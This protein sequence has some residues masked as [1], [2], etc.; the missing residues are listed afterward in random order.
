LGIPCDKKTSR[1]RLRT[2]NEHMKTNLL[3]LVATFMV[4]I[5]NATIL[6]VNNNPAGFAQYN[7]IQA[8]INAAESGDTILVHGSETV[9]AGFTINNKKLAIIGPGVFPE[10]NLGVKGHCAEQCNYRG[11]RYRFRGTG[12]YIR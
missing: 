2:K 6:T 12:L 10:K 8:A 4:I 11:R 5:A 3:L 1:Q 7:T 9:Y